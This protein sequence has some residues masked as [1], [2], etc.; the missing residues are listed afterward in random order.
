MNMNHGILKT[1]NLWRSIIFALSIAAL[2][3]FTALARISAQSSTP[4]ATTDF[5]VSNGVK[6]IHRR[7]QG[8]DVVA[9]QVYFRGGSRNITEKNAGIES[10][11]F[12]VAQQGTK[13]FPK[14]VINR[15]IARM[16]T[17]I[18]SASGYDFSV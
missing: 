5:T 16:G 13:N 2:S 15:E 12:E 8:N 11:L 7:V 1:N 4:E 17:I 14:G 10:L 9:V 18:D 3:S 6:T